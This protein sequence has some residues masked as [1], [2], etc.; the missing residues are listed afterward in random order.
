MKESFADVKKNAR[1]VNIAFIP[2]ICLILKKKYVDVF[3][4][5]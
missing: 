2:F 3:Q 5:A 4:H 1:A